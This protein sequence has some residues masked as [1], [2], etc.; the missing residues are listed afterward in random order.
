MHVYKDRWD[1]PIGEV[2]YTVNKKFGNR[3]DSCAVVVACATLRGA[4]LI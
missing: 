1:T 3:R 2:L 4:L